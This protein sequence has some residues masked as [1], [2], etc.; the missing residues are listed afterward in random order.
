MIFHYRQRN[1][2][3][4]KLNLYINNTKIDQV[5]E[6]NFLGL[7]L[8]D[9]MTWNTHIQ[10][11]ASKISVVNGILSRLKKFIPSDVLKS[12]Y[13][14]LI[15]PHLNFGV[16]L[17]GKNV[18]RIHKLQKWAVRAITSS[19]YNAHTDPLFIKLKLLKIH[20]I[21]KQSLL[22]FYFK[23]KKET[24]PIFFS[25]MFDHIYPTHNYAT[26]LREQPVIARCRTLVAKNSLRYSLPQEILN[27]PKNI[28]DKLSTHSF[29]GFSSYAKAYFIS[30]YNPSC[31]TE[32]CYICNNS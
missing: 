14:A 11:I 21:Y 9:C 31:F 24:L 5:N 15:Q 27:T 1:I 7:L 25:G 32:N 8:D 28:L 23:Y 10:K 12:I 2:S 17:W 3:N 26:R 20:D 22:K 30:L 13:N 6:F 18:K 16:L 4:L 19:K 29:Y